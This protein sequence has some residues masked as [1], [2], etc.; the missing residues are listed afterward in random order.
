METNSNDRIILETIDSNYL[1]KFRTLSERL[2]SIKFPFPAP[3]NPEKPLY[4][5]DKFKQKDIVYELKHV[6]PPST[7]YYK[8]KDWNFLNVDLTV[9]FGGTESP[10]VDGSMAA[11]LLGQLVCQHE[12]VTYTLNKLSSGFVS[13]F[14]LLEPFIAAILAWFIFRER[15]G[16][17]NWAAFFVVLTGIYLA[18][19]SRLLREN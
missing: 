5:W 4:F 8:G 11:I 18:K 7:L 15:L 14:L 10:T 12:I 16:I 19:S 1:D 2:K 13:I 3:T 9:G 6:E 17:I